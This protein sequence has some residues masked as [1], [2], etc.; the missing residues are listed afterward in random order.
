VILQLVEI[1]SVKKKQAKK[2][3][4]KILAKDAVLNSLFTIS[5]RL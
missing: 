3:D 1:Q 4:P 2:S 5:Y